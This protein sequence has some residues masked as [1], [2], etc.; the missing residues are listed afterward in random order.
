MN[1][2]DFLEHF[3]NQVGIKK[4]FDKDSFIRIEFGELAENFL[5]N[6]NNIENST[7]KLA[8]IFQ[9]ISEVGKAQEKNRILKNLMNLI[10]K[11]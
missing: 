11:E 3:K 6:L 2:D 7:L 10:T 8:W 1:D 9:K 5:N 4:E